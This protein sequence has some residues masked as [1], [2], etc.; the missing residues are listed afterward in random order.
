MI[1]KFVLKKSRRYL[2][3]KTP[4]P[5]KQVLVWEDIR[6]VVDFEDHFTV[7][8]NKKKNGKICLDWSNTLIKNN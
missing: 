7:N 1:R 4:N 8:P 3:G 6:E 5:E 2:Q